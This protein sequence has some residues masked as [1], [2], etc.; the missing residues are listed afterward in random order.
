MAE[1]IVL[2][3]LRRALRRAARQRRRSPVRTGCMLRAG[4]SP[5]PQLI[6]CVGPTYQQ[7]P[8]AKPAGRSQYTTASPNRAAASLI[9]PLFSSRPISHVGPSFKYYQ[10]LVQVG[11]RPI[12]GL[13]YPC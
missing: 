9:S 11:A 1:I 2:T 6:S 5:P 8:P 12:L 4:L 7:R 10:T 13:I 3:E